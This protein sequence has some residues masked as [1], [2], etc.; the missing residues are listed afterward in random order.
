MAA[1]VR[2]YQ[3][4]P[5]NNDDPSVDR[6]ALV[7]A[8]INESWGGNLRRVARE[9]AGAAADTR[10]IERWRRRLYR[11]R[12]G[13]SLEAENA[14]PIAELLRLDPSI[15]TRPATEA[16]PGLRQEAVGRIAAAAERVAAVAARLDER[17]EEQGRLQEGQAAASA[18]LAAV[19]AQLAQLLGELSGLLAEQRAVVVQLGNYVAQ[20]KQH[21]AAADAE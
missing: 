15:L 8:A 6:A 13:A 5:A 18:Q 2:D 11:L 1:H 16:S 14:E 17:F 7:I 19:G 12:D 10:E 20:L 9:L 4:M 3:R 21:Q